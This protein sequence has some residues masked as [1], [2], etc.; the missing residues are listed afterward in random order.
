MAPK[1]IPHQRT[2]LSLPVIVAALGYFIDIYDL[3]FFSIVRV[4]SLKEHSK[5]LRISLRQS[6]KTSWSW[7]MS[8]LS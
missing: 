8:D 7:N 5:C 1:T 3:V 4:P 2:M 6:S